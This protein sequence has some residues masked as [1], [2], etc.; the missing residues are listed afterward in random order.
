[1]KDDTIYLEHIL[2]A[3][4]KIE[5]AIQDTPNK[6]DFLDHENWQTQEVVFRQIEIIGEA[7]KRLSSDFREKYST[8]PW[9]QIAGMR[10]HL[11]HEYFSINYERVWE[12]IQKDIPKFKQQVEH[13]LEN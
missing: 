6:D 11:I 5:I 4:D 7:V 9:R 3:I 10:D 12:T 8:T 1:M 13:M 2:E